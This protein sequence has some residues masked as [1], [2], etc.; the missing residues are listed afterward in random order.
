MAAAPE[1]PGPEERLAAEAVAAVLPAASD[2]AARAWDLEPAARFHPL[3]A[4]PGG[5]P[6]WPSAGGRAAAGRRGPLEA[7]LRRAAEAPAAAA[8]IAAAYR[9]RIAERNP[10][11]SAFLLVCPEDHP[12]ARPGPGALYGAALGCKD[13]VETAGLRT[14]GGSRQRLEHVPRRDATCWARLR[15][16]GAVCL[17]KTNTHEFAAGTTSENDW[18]GPVRN[19]HDPGRVAG[20]SSGGSAAA[21]AAGCCAAALG[22]DTGGSVRIPAACCGVVGFKP[23]YGRVSRAGVFALSWSLDHVGVLACS[24]RDAALVLRVMAGPDPADATTA[25]WAAFPPPRPGA[26]DRLGRPRPGGLRGLRLGV[27]WSWLEEAGPTA[28]A[29]GGLPVA[30]EVAAAFERALGALR[31]LGG[32]IVPVELGG[33]DFATAVNRLL[34]LPESAAYHAAD[35]DGRPEGFG[36]RIRPRLL[37]GRLL[38]AE[39]YLQGQRLRS[40]LCRRYADAVAQAGVHLIATPT[41]PR[42]A[43]AI[44]APSTEA[45]ALLRFCAPWNVVGWP[46]ASLP[47]APGPSGLPC[48]LQ[49]CAPPGAD[50]AL[51]G[52]AAAAEPALA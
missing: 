24:V 40:L 31:D 5:V 17:G 4:W 42:P 43:P 46:A 22:T 52:A 34:A 27:P 21:V 10:D 23:T 2:A 29:T 37:G 9:R 47:C 45:L 12:Q 25:D 13:I 32:E 51:L 6:R 3:D 49:L 11:L 30:P 7:D 19:P 20:G 26:P 50:A 18:F 1:V 41:L 39:A 8:E 15:A 33:A 48:G 35:L 38:P 28:P 44:G 16:A 14:T 36:A